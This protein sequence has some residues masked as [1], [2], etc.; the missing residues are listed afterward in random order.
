MQTGIE[1]PVMNV[2]PVSDD[3]FGF[4]TSSRTRTVGVPKAVKWDVR[5]L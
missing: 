3:C 5:I 2:L 1:V 4:N